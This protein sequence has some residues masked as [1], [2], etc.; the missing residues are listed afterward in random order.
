MS[1]T[2]D[3]GH[4]VT[5]TAAIRH[6]LAHPWDVFVA[7]WNWK[8]ALLG[9]IF[10]GLA[11]ALPMAHL[12]GHDAARTLVI[13]LAFR[14]V[15]GGFWG[16]LLQAFRGARPAWLAGLFVCIAL[17]GTAHLL[18][19]AALQAGHV[20]HIRTGMTVSIVI[21]IGSLLINL[22]LM[23]RGLLITGGD[24]ASLRSDLQRIPAALA[25]MFRGLARHES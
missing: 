14:L 13:E 16:S 3:V 6:V 21:S 25:A 11:F 17:P 20:S 24:A 9:A 12:V 22:G 10:R 23:R 19:F 15:V 2:P 8:A 18:E 5:V 1:P 7:R 4:E